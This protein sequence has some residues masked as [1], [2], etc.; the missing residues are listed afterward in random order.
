[1][2]LSTLR[3][4]R[5]KTLALAKKHELIVAVEAGA[6]SKGEI[7][8]DFRI[9]KTV[10]HHIIRHLA[11]AK[12]NTKE[13]FSTLKDI[14][15]TQLDIFHRLS[16]LVGRHNDSEEPLNTDDLKIPLR[17]MEDFNDLED[18]LGE[19]TRREALKRYLAGY[20]GAGLDA[21]TRAIMSRV[22]H[23]TLQL[24]FNMHGKKG[25]KVAFKGTSLCGVV[26]GAIMQ[27]APG[28]ETLT[29]Q[30]TVGRFLAGAADRDGGR[31]RRKS[32]L[33]VADENAPYDQITL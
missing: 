3:Q 16:Q 30:K 23:P 13:V 26:V 28:V 9:P 24:K 32:V 21:A 22:L 33:G 7:A 31:R 5:L 19:K 18:L 20:G 2:S 10:E 14:Q 12:Q 6:K 25:N 11:E 15:R 29:V 4:R 17:T 27:R 8:A 1:M